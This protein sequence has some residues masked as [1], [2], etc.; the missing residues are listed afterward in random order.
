VRATPVVMALVTVVIAL[1]G[2]GGG[3]GIEATPATADLPTAASP[4]PAAPSP[5][6]DVGGN[7]K[8]EAPVEPAPP[9]TSSPE[10]ELVSRDRS[11]LYV[12]KA[13]GGE[14]AVLALEASTRTTLRTLVLDGIW[15]LSTV[16][17]DG[18][19]TGLSADGRTLVLQEAPDAGHTRFAVIDTS[20]GGR[21][22]IVDL[23]G[24]YALDGVAVDGTGL[25]LL[26]YANEVGHEQ[27]DIVAYDV[28]A[29]RLSEPLVDKR[30]PDEKMQGQ[31]LARVTS[32]GGDWAYTLYGGDHAFVHAL[33]LTRAGGATV[34]I[35]LDGLPLKTHAA[36]QRWILTLS[37]DGKM[38]TAANPAAGVDAT[39]DLAHFAQV[40]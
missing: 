10:T 32:P 21:P 24:R 31:A 33:Q 28:L 5:S 27:Y 23:S 25:F 15:E 18:S 4:P 34:C 2:C 40:A 22:E 7:P 26:R 13:S 30:N 11:T 3:T 38:L 35:D 17:A 12:V 19:V 6:L 1:A 9:D 16:A 14:T 39:V 37:A 29:D 36:G 8:A 20:F